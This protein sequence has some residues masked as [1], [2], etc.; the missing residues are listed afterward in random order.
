MNPKPLFPLFRVTVR[1]GVH[2]FSAEKTERGPRERNMSYIHTLEKSG[3]TALS[4]IS[5]AEIITIAASVYKC[6]ILDFYRG[7]QELV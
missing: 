4:E 7:Y 2:L 1:G 6:S 5:D 3:G